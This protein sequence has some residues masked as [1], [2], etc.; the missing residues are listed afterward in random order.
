ML[1]TFFMTAQCMDVGSSDP[2][3]YVLQSWKTAY[4]DG[5]EIANHSYSHTTGSVTDD[6][7]W[8]DEIGRANDLLKTFVSEPILGWRGPFLGYN[9]AMMVVLQE[10]GFA[11]DTTIDEGYELDINGTNH[12]WPY[13]WDSGRGAERRSGA[14]RQVPTRL[15]RRVAGFGV[16]IGSEPQPH[17]NMNAAGQSVPAKRENRLACSSVH[18]GPRARNQALRRMLGVRFRLLI[19][20][21]GEPPRRPPPVL[22]RAG[23]Q[24]R[25]GAFGRFDKTTALIQY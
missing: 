21:G 13:T 20:A 23:R 12:Y 11:Y 10:L 25:V 19:E 17:A 15:G 24:T 18:R 7:S 14:S 1:T 9:D 2:P 8:R 4:A 6:A 16:G 5:H 3:E 22:P